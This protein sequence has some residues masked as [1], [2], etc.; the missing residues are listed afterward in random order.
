[1]RGGELYCG[2]CS[3][4]LR[5][6]FEISSV[7][8]EVGD[9]FCRRLT[10]LDC[11]GCKDP[12][13][14]RVCDNCLEQYRIEKVPGDGEREAWAVCP[15][16]LVVAQKMMGRDTGGPKLHID[17]VPYTVTGVVESTTIRLDDKV[18]FRNLGKS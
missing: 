8:S 16:A 1:L 14:H 3:R 10:W 7:G 17:G 12:G 11:G 18:R 15:D 2:V 4:T 13:S 6:A 5:A 9:L